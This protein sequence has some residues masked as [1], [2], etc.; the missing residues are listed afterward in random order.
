M[1]EF[2]IYPNFLNPQICLDCWA[3]LR[4]EMGFLKQNG[5]EDIETDLKTSVYFLSNF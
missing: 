2:I 5:T 3:E 4:L 1:R